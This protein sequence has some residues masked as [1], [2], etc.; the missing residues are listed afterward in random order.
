MEIL[1]IFFSS[2]IYVCIYVL[3]MHVCLVFAFSKINALCVCLTQI[4]SLGSLGCQIF[5]DNHVKGYL[6]LLADL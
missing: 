2:H 6:F 1:S 5:S 4:A 3:H